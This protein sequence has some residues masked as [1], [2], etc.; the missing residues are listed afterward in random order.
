MDGADRSG[1]G[2]PEIQPAVDESPAGDGVGAA[3]EEKTSVAVA[4]IPLRPGDEPR[5]FDPVGADG[6]YN[7]M[8]KKLT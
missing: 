2:H 7:L 6:G 8:L 4:V 3:G 1:G 5:V